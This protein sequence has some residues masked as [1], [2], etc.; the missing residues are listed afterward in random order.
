MTLN[1]WVDTVLE[2]VVLDV[3][4]L[5]GACWNIADVGIRVDATTV[6]NVFWVAITSSTAGTACIS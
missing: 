3:S 5:K 1:E 2:V 4:F 6:M